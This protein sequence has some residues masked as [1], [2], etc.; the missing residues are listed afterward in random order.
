LHPISLSNAR[1]C[2][3][4]R[5]ALAVQ[6]TDREFLLRVSYLEIYNETERDLLNPSGKEQDLQIRESKERGVFV[7]NLKEEIVTS[8]ERVLQVMDSGETQRHY[9][10]TNMNDFSSRSHTIFRLVT[11]SAPRAPPTPLSLH[12]TALT[13]TH[14]LS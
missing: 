2:A 7:D 13:A 6:T 9:G 4:S 1:S 3:R 11:T 14:L 12:R 8:V 5:P 10:K